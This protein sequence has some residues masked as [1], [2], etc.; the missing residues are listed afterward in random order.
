MANKVMPQIKNVVFLMLENRSLDNLLGWLYYGNPPPLH[1]YPKN[2]PRDYDGLYPGR[3]FNP[4]YYREKFPPFRKK[5]KDYS[6]VPVP[7]GLGKNQDRVPA[8]DPYEE[9]RESGGGWNGVMN[10]LFGNQDEIKGLPQPPTTPHM[11]GFLQDYYADYMVDW[12]GLDIL[13]TYTPSQVKHLNGLAY[14]FAVSDRWF[15]SVPSQTNPNRAF[16]LC[17][18]SLGRESN[19]HKNAVEQFNVP[20]IFNGM[21]SAN[22]SWGLYFTDVW[23]NNLSYTEYTFPQISN[24]KSAGET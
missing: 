21:A 2:S 7:N 5:V 24:V 20:T 1:V 12:K 16:S 6:V 15:C 19:L 22:K 11:L 10:Q 13:W 4:A 18:T 23:K 14:N 9:L 8:Y 17:G 3:Y